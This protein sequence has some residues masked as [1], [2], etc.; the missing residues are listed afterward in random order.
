MNPNTSILML[1]GLARERRHWGTV[2]DMIQQQTEK[3]VL[4]PDLPGFGNESEVEPPMSIRQTME[5]IRQ[6]LGAP[7]KLDIVGLSL[8]GMVVHEWVRHY[9]EEIN[10]F[11]MINSS[12]GSISPFYKRLRWQIYKQIIDIS[13]AQFPRER[14]RKILEIVANSAER[15]EEVLLDWVKV[16]QERNWNPVHV[17]KQISAAAI[18]RPS[19]EPLKTSGLVLSCLGDRFM[20]PS[21]PA[22]LAKALKVPLISHPWAGHDLGVD[23][24]KWLVDRLAEFWKSLN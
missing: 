19:I 23:D 10:S 13:L 20:D 17:L 1:R 14:E 15:R 22:T 24:P 4:T 8:G 21:C 16:A 7:K 9:P 18:Y 11:V 5:M 12:F 2:I 3:E 6:K